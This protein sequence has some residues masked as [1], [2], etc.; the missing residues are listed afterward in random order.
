MWLETLE[1]IGSFVKWSGHTENSRISP[2]NSGFIWQDGIENAK[3][4][5]QSQ[6]PFQTFLGSFTIKQPWF[7]KLEL[8]KYGNTNHR[9]LLEI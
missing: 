5:E 9:L 7:S 4:G 6:L 3:N 2:D 8:I 1:S